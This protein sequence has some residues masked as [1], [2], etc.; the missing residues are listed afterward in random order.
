MKANKKAIKICKPC[1]MHRKHKPYHVN[2]GKRFCGIGHWD[3]ADP[4][5]LPVCNSSKEVL[6]PSHC[7]KVYHKRTKRRKNELE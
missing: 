5:S 1:R 3:E 4:N 2:S 6:L 7:K